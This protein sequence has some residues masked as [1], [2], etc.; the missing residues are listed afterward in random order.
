MFPMKIEGA[1]NAKTTKTG[2]TAKASIEHKPLFQHCDNTG[3]RYTEEELEKRARS[4]Y[5][6]KVLIEI[7]FGE[8]KFMEFSVVIFRG[9]TELQPQMPKETVGENKR[10]AFNL[11][12]EETE[13]I[14][15]LALRALRTEKKEQ[16]EL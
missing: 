15:K 5:A 13:A 14:M 10:N 7:M 4:K 16:V 1:M 11:D 6:G 12:V 9:K 3:R 2:I 8:R